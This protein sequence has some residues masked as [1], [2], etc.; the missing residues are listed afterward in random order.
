LDQLVV[1]STEEKVDFKEL[2]KQVFDDDKMQNKCVACKD[3]HKH[4]TRTVKISQA[5]Q[6]LRFVFKRF[7]IDPFTG[8]PLYKIHTMV[9]YPRE[10]L[11]IETEQG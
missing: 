2:L 11:V 3:E 1:P 8:K 10:G 9:K 7:E 6:I 5:P 4:V